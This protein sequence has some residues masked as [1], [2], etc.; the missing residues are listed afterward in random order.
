MLGAQ[1]ASIHNLGFYLSLVAQA[2]NHI[3]DDTFCE[4]KQKMVVQLAQRI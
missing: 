3:V 2:R 4:W 1:I